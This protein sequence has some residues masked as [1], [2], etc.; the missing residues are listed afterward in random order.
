MQREKL[1]LT[2]RDLRDQ[3]FSVTVTSR[4]RRIWSRSCHGHDLYGHGR[5]HEYSYEK[6]EFSVI[7]KVD[8]SLKKNV[9]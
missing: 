4:S 8:G 2:I 7:V 5:G 1:R 3:G 6:Y 9:K